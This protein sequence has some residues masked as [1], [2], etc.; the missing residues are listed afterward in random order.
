MTGLRRL[1]SDFVAKSACCLAQN[2]DLCDGSLP[3]RADG[4]KAS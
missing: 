4:K 3:E 2:D 1:D